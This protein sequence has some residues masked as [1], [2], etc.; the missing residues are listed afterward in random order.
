MLGTTDAEV[1]SSG[2]PAEK[3][4]QL[5]RR[6]RYLKNERTSWDS[7]W[8]EISNYLLPRSG[9]FFV[10]D[11]NRGQKRH[12][13]ITDNTATR[14]LRTLASGMMAGATSPARPWFALT[15]SDPELATFH[16][17]RIW[18]EDTVRRMH[19]VFQLSN[20]YR[21]LHQ[22]YEEIGAF[23]T[24]ASIIVPDFD[25]VIHHHV[26][27]V[28]EYAMQQDHK[29]QVNTLFR[30]FQMT[31]EQLVNEFGYEN[32]STTV[33]RHWDNRVYDHVVTVI[34][35]IEPRHKRDPSK[36][37]NTN[38]PWQSCYFELGVEDD[39][40]LRE[41]GF[42]DFPVL[43]PRWSVTGGDIYGSS[44]GMDALGDIKQLQQEQY[45]KSQGIDYMSKPPLQAPM[46]MKGIDERML[47]GSITFSDAQG[48]IRTAFEV[49]LDLEHLLNDIYDVRERI[50]G[51][52]YA[53]LFLMLSRSGPDTRMTAT[54]VA[55]RHEE[56]LLMLGPVLE[57]LHNELLKPMIDITFKRMLEVGALLPPPPDLEGVDLGVEFE[58]VLAQAQRAIGTNSMDRFVGAVGVVAQMK[59]E[60]LDKL[61]ADA[62]F[63][64]YGQKLGVDS[65]IMVPT[66]QAQK[67]REARHK[68]EAAA[69]QIQAAATQAKATK[70]LASAN[71]SNPGTTNDVMS[72]LTGYNSPP[73]ET[74]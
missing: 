52:F 56:K 16:P 44:P 30:E 37:D 10:E 23:G 63:D 61:D 2:S 55:E 43:A 41:T 34:H 22:I 14:A 51:A 46:S 17:V 18:L 74:Y 57:R 32:C 3:R 36:A 1:Y 26:L 21:A 40:L 8:K 64:R 12:N 6:W 29:G 27:T 53:D 7:H 38:M 70:D 31:V 39:R 71:E 11:R 68:A 69:A 48:G 4:K 60:V 59:P 15:T 35:G 28:G 19:R 25:N 9:R 42:D 24:A 50:N 47:P 49:K 65:E 20:T 73:A 72:Q 5:I 62:W 54:E 66:E 67:I 33:K 45:R 58:S 13:L